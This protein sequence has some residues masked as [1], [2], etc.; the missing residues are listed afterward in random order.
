MNLNPWLLGTAVWFV[1]SGSIC[2]YRRNNGLVDIF[3]GLGFVILAAFTYSSRTIHSMESLVVTG[4]ILIW[5][6]RL[7]IYLFSRNWNK[8]EDFRYANWRKGWGTHWVLSSIL[9]V[10][11]LQGVI[12]QAIAIPIFVTNVMNQAALGDLAKRPSYFVVMGGLI[13]LVGIVIEA[14][15]DRQ[16]S[17]FKS[18]SLNE[19]K[20]CRVGLWKISRHPNYLGEIINWIGI[21]I[22]PLGLEWGWIAL[23][24]PLLI[25]LLLYF[26]SGVPLL[27]K[28][29]EGRPDF[30]DYKRTTGAIFPKLIGSKCP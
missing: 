7:S 27:E 17:I 18:D 1:I 23:I 16:K 10:Y 8:P 29:L 22:V 24:S 9:K 15:S 12:M 26:V 3:W 5:G 4:L 6:L 28:R 19:Q 30:E 21:G 2:L 14:M 13:S 25:T 20:L 11:V